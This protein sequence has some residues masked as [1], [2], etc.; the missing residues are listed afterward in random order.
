MKVLFWIVP[1]LLLQFYCGVLYFTGS[2]MFNKAMRTRALERGFTL[3]EARIRCSQVW[4]LGFPTVLWIKSTTEFEIWPQSELICAKLDKSTRTAVLDPSPGR[5]LRAAGA[6]AGLERGGHLRLHRL[7]L[8]DAQREEH[9]S[10]KNQFEAVLALW[11]ENWKVQMGT[12]VWKWS[13]KCNKFSI[14]L[15][16]LS[17]IIIHH[18]LGSQWSH[19]ATVYF[20]EVSINDC[21]CCALQNDYT[22][23]SVWSVPRF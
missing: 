20:F 5:G 8:Q 1:L 11:R 18:L 13:C 21:F 16:T 3:N 14:I 17:Y 19:S 9:L 4:S 7:R 10:R 12:L 22:R 23:W 2:D 15:I 6:A